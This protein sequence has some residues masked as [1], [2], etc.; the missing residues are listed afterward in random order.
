[1]TRPAMPRRAW[2]LVLAFVAACGADDKQGLTDVTTTADTVFIPD[3]TL[4]DSF[5]VAPETTT[6][7][8]VEEDVPPQPGEFGYTCDENLDCNSGYCVQTADGRQCTRACID[9]CPSGYDCRLAPGTDATFICLPRFLHICDPC[10]ET[11]ECNEGGGAG[12]YCLGYGEKGRFCGVQCNED[13]DCPGGYVCRNVPVGGGAEAKQ[14]VPED[15]AECTCSPYA[16]QAQ[17][18]TTCSVENANGKCEGTRFCLQSGLSLCDAATPFPES[19]NQLDDNCNGQTDEF[20]PDY[21]CEIT[22]EF[23]ACPGKGSC[24]DGFETCLGDAPA[25]DICDLKDND[26]DGETDNG[27]CDDLNPC[28]TDSCDPN[29]GECIHVEDNTRLCDDGDVCTQVDKC[30]GGKCTGFNPV[31]CGD[32]NPCKTWQCDPTVGCLS[33]F[34]TDPCEDGNPCTVN[35]KCNLGACVAGGPNNCDDQNQCTTD[36]CVA[37]VGCTHNNLPNTTSCVKDGLTGC[38][39]SECTNGQCVAKNINSTPS[40][41]FI[42]TLGGECSTGY[43]AAGQCKVLGGSTCTATIDYL[44]CSDD[45][46]GA[47]T[48]SGSCE[49]L[50][51][52]NQCNCGPCNSFCATLCDTFCVCLDFLFQ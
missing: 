27:L 3:V 29:T 15:G 9:S 14:C 2:T 50:N 13:P 34:N 39:T 17:R 40:N 43:C 21:T 18:A 32:G 8:V 7:D 41:P 46:A 47:C 30:S 44:F 38:Q 24:V 31:V 51:Q 5:T 1:M 22:N 48:V 37:G 11:S 36:S 45:V 4:F 12:N 26:C 19:C 23:G 16:K 42:C 20:P 28:T 6:P 10:R 49:P 52:G 33:S 35:D 25:P